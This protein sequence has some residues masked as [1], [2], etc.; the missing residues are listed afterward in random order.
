MNSAMCGVASLMSAWYQALAW[1]GPW[2]NCFVVLR[3]AREVN[4]EAVLALKVWKQLNTECLE[5]VV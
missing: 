3:G 2:E 4:L 1:L 5:L